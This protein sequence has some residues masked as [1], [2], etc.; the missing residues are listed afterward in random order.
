MATIRG[1]LKFSSRGDFLDQQGRVLQLKGINIDGLSKFPRFP[2]ALPS[3]IPE[4]S[5]FFTDGDTVSFVGRPWPLDEV[6]EN[7]ARLKSMGFNT[8]RY[9]ITWEALEHS[10]PGIYDMEFIRYT[11]EVLKIIDK[12]GGMFVYLDPHQD[13]WSRFSGG[14]GA[15]LWTLYAAGFDPTSF[16]ATEGAIVQNQYKEEEYHKMIWP[17]NYLR[18]VAGTMFVLFFAGKSFAPKAIINGVNIQDFLQQH[19]TKSFQILL[20]NIVAQAPEILE[21]TLLG[22]ETLNEPNAGYLGYPDISLH[23]STQELRLGTCPTLLDSL[24]LGMGQKVEVDEYKISISGPKKIGTKE[25]DPKGQTI[26]LQT[27]AF[28][29]KYGFARDYSSWPLGK[30]I[31]EQHGVWN[32]STGEVLQ[33]DYFAV[34]EGVEVDEKY[35][36]NKFFIDHYRLFREAM[37]SAWPQTILFLQQPPLELP[38]D[39]SRQKSSLIDSRTVICPHYY[40]GCSLLFK[41]WNRLYNVNTLR[42][43][44]HK[45]LSPIFSVILGESNIRRSIR[46]QLSQ[47]RDECRK[48]VGP[49]VPVLFSEI[50]MPFDMDDKRAFANGDFSSQRDALD[51]LAFALEGSNLSHT[52]WCYTSGNEHANGDGFNG[53]DFSF[54]S[55]DDVVEEDDDRSSS[56]SF[57]LKKQGSIKEY[58]HSLISERD[59][60]YQYPPG[61][62]STTDTIQFQ[63]AHSDLAVEECSPHYGKSQAHHRTSQPNEEDTDDPHSPALIPPPQATIVFSNKNNN[64][65][66]SN[67]NNNFHYYNGLRATDAIIRPYSLAINGEFT[68]AEFD[69]STGTYLLKINAKDRPRIPTRIYLPQWHCQ[70]VQEDNNSPQVFVEITSGY[71]QLGMSNSSSSEDMKGEGNEHEVLEWFH[72]SGEQMLIIKNLKG[73]KNSNIVSSRGFSYNSDSGLVGSLLSYF[74]PC[75]F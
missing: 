15:P 48:L 31:W 40:D 27:R 51:A 37:R 67:N 12:I 24:K 62:S 72:E 60:D 59:S 22:I 14:D 39:L 69:I 35:F 2:K 32:S 50:G 71:Y 45:N 20:E 28:D 18:L 38:P 53:E 30:C 8:L 36:I 75:Y 7:V 4:S 23:P 11:I 17:T 57:S 58:Q 64:H 21:R 49:S 6:Q 1:P 34:L 41:T 3:H 56:R 16:K 25:I 29:E 46:A 43:M 9:I 54:W 66:N 47:M 52:W 70:N 63:D 19:Y 55:Q 13:V 73:K 44:R 26:W 65:N 68:T 10:G 61:S 33:S 74:L 42:I 5:S